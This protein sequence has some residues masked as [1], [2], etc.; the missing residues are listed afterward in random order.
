ML[1][2][3]WCSSP[4]GVWVIRKNDVLDLTN[5][6]RATY[7]RILHIFEIHFNS[8]TVWPLWDRSP[9]WARQFIGFFVA[10]QRV[11]RQSQVRKPIGSG[12]E[13]VEYLLIIGTGYWVQVFAW[14]SM[15]HSVFQR[16]F[17]LLAVPETLVRILHSAEEEDNLSHFVNR[18]PPT[19]HRN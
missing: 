18:L 2:K 16:E 5:P 15:A 8:T 10:Y 14:S 1:A 19:E 13:W 17:S 7:E 6:Q 9:H 3:A 4:S 12:V 11:Y